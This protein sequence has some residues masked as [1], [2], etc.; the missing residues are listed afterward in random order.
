MVGTSQ[1]PK[2]PSQA[3]LQ[4]SS[5][6]ISRLRKLSIDSNFTRSESTVWH[7]LLTPNCWPHKAALKISNFLAYKRNMLVVWDVESG[8]S[9]YGTPNK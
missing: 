3:S 2:T 1:V 7:F 8:K 4:T 5:F 6:G 9:L